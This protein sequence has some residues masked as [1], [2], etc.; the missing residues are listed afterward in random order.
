MDVAARFHA[1]INSLGRPS[2]ASEVRR[3]HERVSRLLEKHGLDAEEGRYHL[4]AMIAEN[5]LSPLSD[6]GVE[7][8]FSRHVA[9]VVA[10]L[11]DSEGFFELSRIDWQD[12]HTYAQLWDFRSHLVLQKRVLDDLDRSMSLVEQMI[13]V[14]LEPIVEACPSVLSAQQAD[15]DAAATV[16]LRSWIKAFPEALERVLLVPFAEELEK[17][18]LFVRLRSRL[19]SNIIVASGGDPADPKAKRVTTRLPTKATTTDPAKLVDDYLGGTALAWLF[20]YKVPFKIPER[21]RFEH[22]H[23][24]A[25]SGHGKTQTLQYLIAQDLERVESGQASVVVIDSQGDLIRNIARLRCFAPGEPLHD[26]ICIV[27]P[28]DVEYPVA[29]NLFDVGAERLDRYSR[30]D[31]ERLTNSVLELYDFVLGSLLSAEMTQKQSVVFRY[32]TRLMLHIPNATIHTFRELLEPGG[33]EKYREHIDKLHGTARAFF[34]TEFTH[35]SFEDTRR[36]VVRRLW[37]ILEN[38][39]F[40]RMFSHPKNKL[41]LF[42]ELNAGK[43]FLINTAKDLLKEQ[44]TEIFGRFFI[45]MIAQAAQ[46][47]ATIPEKDRMPTYV[48]IDEAQDYFDRNI[49][50][51]LSQARKYSVGMVLAH[52]GL[53]QLEPKLQDAF[54]ANTSIK[55]AGGVSVKDARAFAPMLRTTIEFIEAQPKG[56]FAAHVRGLTSTAV[57]V[58]FPFGYMEKMPKM[59]AASREQLSA[60]MRR[61]YAVHYTEVGAQGADGE[62]GSTDSQG[63]AGEASAKRKGVR[64]GGKTSQPW[65][66]KPGEGLDDADTDASEEW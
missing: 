16:P 61:K 5:A 30:L 7:G 54:S 34:E 58:S 19:E 45:A 50:I 8:E 26:R 37:G 31:R 33:E 46:E 23:I 44:G 6:D 47:R 62:P 57:P 65:T 17:A 66:K 21:T 10:G 3:L 51:I 49:G 56:T 27:D 36:Q 4:A 43:I 22:H 55:F 38:Q 29:L 53:F 14:I 42:S 2:E 64:P 12:S 24:V 48:Y 15:R 1:L 59:D 41:D 60:A 63:D 39:T 11:L 20:G 35:K 32:I 52:Q 28:E 40:E 18:E 9:S 13:E 25:G